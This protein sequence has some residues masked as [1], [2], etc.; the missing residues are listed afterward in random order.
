MNKQ[1]MTAGQ[2]RVRA[3]FNPNALPM[4]EAIKSQTATLLDTMDEL[5][6]QVQAGTP[7]TP[8]HKNNLGDFMREVATAKTAIQDA[9][10]WAVLAATHDSAMLVT[11]GEKPETLEETRW[12]SFKE[13]ETYRLWKE[14]KEK[15]AIEEIK[16]KYATSS[17]TATNQQK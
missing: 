17:S 11:K 6:K 13:W 12:V 10:M 1:D 14:G 5:V 2:K 16:K 7:N 4:V 3:S 8:E 15:E 9:S